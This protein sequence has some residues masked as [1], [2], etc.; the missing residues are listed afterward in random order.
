VKRVLNENNPSG[1][2]VQNSVRTAFV[3]NL[4]SA[5]KLEITNAPT[6]IALSDVVV[7]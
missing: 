4:Q 2:P 5:K 7:E 3:I 6:M 1:L